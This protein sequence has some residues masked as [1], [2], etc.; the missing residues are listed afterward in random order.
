MDM[1]ERDRLIAERRAEAYRKPFNPGT[2]PEHKPSPDTRIANA[3]E[4][5]AAQLGTIARA[6]EKIEQHLQPPPKGDEGTPS[7]P[8][9]RRL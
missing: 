7:E 8:R 1:A 6:A 4:Y 2:T 3:L 9:I 5:I